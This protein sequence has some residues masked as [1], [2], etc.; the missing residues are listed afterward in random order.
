MV[1]TFSG[2]GVKSAIGVL[3]AILKPLLVIILKAMHRSAPAIFAELVMVQIFEMGN[4]IS[5]SCFSEI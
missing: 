3:M 4:A 1:I 2:S 5:Q